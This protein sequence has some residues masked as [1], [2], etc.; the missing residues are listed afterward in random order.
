M[1]GVFNHILPG[2]NEQE[3]RNRFSFT[4]RRQY[5]GAERPLCVFAAGGEGPFAAQAVTAIS[6][7]R[8]L[9]RRIGTAQKRIG[10]FTPDIGL[11]L[12]RKHRQQPLMGRQQA[13][14]PTGRRTGGRKLDIS[15]DQ[16]GEIST[17][18]AESARLDDIEISNAAQRLDMACGN[19]P[20]LLRLSGAHP[21]KIGYAGDAA[22]EADTRVRLRRQRRMAH[23]VHDCL[24][25][26]VTGRT[27]LAG[28]Y[29][30]G[31]V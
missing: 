1:P 4:P 11:R 24:L 16:F 27:L 31:I 21:E 23:I 25:P 13:G 28:G 12:F 30:A 15:L 20:G 14:D 17:L 7:L 18:A 29:P 19:T 2:R 26:D 10:V 9:H 22:C 6:E 8:H 5:G 3:G